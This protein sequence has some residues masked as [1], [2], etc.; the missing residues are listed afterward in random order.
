MLYIPRPRKKMRRG[1]VAICEYLPMCKMAGR[2]MMP[3]ERIQEQPTT[4]KTVR[5]LIAD[6]MRQVRQDLRALLEL[7]AE[8]EVVGAA[9][10]GQQAVELAEQLC[11]DVIVMDLAMPGMDGFAATREIKKRALA[12]R[13]VI[14]SVHGDAETIE[15]ARDVGADAIVLKGAPFEILCNAIT[16]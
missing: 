13:V 3:S 1:M 4:T 9:A 16:A 8:I 14:L 15:R 12:R 10:N 5:V 7:I 6:D 2:R 11:P